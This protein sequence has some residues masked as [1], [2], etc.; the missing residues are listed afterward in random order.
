[1][2]GGEPLLELKQVLIAV[3][4]AKK[5]GLENGIKSD[6]MII[7]NGVLLT[8]KICQ[9]LKENNLRAA[10][11]LDG[12]GKHHDKTRIF[13]NSAGAFKYVETGIQN[14]LKHKIPFNIS[15]TITSKNI[16]NIPDLT[17]YLL[18]KYPFCVQLLSRKPFC[19][20]KTGD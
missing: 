10:I 2:L 16:E 6:F 9:A 1:M 17:S 7:T 3:N 4:Q 20:R 14:V 12:L 8:E 11:S 15:I 18:K 13:A 5:L 19:C